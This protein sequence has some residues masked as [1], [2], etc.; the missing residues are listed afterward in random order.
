[1]MQMKNGRTSEQWSKETTCTTRTE[2]S[3]AWREITESTPMR[4]IRS[5][6]RRRSEALIN[7]DAFSR[8]L[9]WA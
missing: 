4:S 2:K 9:C 8:L 1:M 5:V 7:L 6:H 3:Y